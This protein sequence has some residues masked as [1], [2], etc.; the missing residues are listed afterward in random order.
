[1]WIFDIGGG[2]RLS[3]GG[4]GGGEVGVSHIHHNRDLLKVRTVMQGGGG[5][6]APG[7]PLVPPPMFEYIAL[8]S[9]Y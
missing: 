8:S 1:M 3:L 2:R 4:G 7:A 5:A 9:I 6:R